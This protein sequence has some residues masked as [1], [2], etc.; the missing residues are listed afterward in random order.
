MNEYVRGRDE[1]GKCLSSGRTLQVQHDTTLVAVDREMNRPHLLRA[2]AAHVPHDV[3]F[4]PLD[5]DHVGAHVAQY[6]H[7]I[8]PHHYGREIDDPHA[9]EHSSHTILASLRRRTRRRDVFTPA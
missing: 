4:R 3:P 1:L 7:C 5:L 6:L 2:P 8:R 9:S